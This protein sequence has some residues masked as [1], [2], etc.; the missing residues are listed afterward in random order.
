MT[1]ALEILVSALRFQNPSTAALD[2]FTDA[3]WK[4]VREQWSLQRLTIFLRQARPEHMPNWVR[5]EI[6]VNLADNA[7][8][9]ER[10]KQTYARV[11]RETASAGAEHV[12]PRDFRTGPDS[13]STLA[14]VTK[15]TSIFSV[16][17]NPFFLL[18]PR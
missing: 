5:D 15:R 3:E 11:A 14:F 13:W 6:D 18:A 10:I 9:F 7:Q 16:L 8:R 1:D 4:S 2:S 12:V 17:T